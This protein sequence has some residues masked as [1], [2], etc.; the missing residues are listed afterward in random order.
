M[1]LERDGPITHGPCSKPLDNIR[2]WLH[3]FNRNGIACLFEAQQA[4]ES[5]LLIELVGQ[6]GELLKGIHRVGA[7]RLLHLCNG[8]GVVQMHFHAGGVAG[9]EMICAGI[10]KDAGLG[11]ALVDVGLDATIGQ[12]VEAQY[13]LCNGLERHTGDARGGALETQVHHFFSNTKRLENLG[14]LVAG[15]RADAHLGHHLKHP[16]INR[17]DVICNG[18]GLLDIRQSL[19]L[20]QRQYG[21]Q[22]QIRTYG[23]RSKAEKGAE[24]VHLVG[25][26]YFEEDGY[27]GA[28][29]E[30]N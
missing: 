14:T 18:L 27:S 7:R 26:G 5:G 25:V 28:G 11:S 30:L 10:G 9:P 2:S 12:V 20:P 23:I 8:H 3:L 21:L 15:Q 22:G 6:A 16:I 17:L 24:V 19:L 4:T 13:V 1:R 29:V